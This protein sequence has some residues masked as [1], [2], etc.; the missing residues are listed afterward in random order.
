DSS[1]RP[2]IAAYFRFAAQ[3]VVQTFLPHLQSKGFR[4]LV[5]GEFVPRLLVALLDGLAMQHYV[6]PQ[7]I[8]EDELLNAVEKMARSLLARAERE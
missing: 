4:L 8:D 6:D 2:P 1:L 3:Q 7:S 5:P